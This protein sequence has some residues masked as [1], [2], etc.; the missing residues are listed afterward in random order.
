MTI[1]LHTT[2]MP[3]PPP[4]PASSHEPTPTGGRL[5]AWAEALG[6]AHQLGSALCQT[7]FV[8]ATFRG[9]PEEAAAAILFGDELGL[10]PTQSLQG[11][12]VVSGRVGMYARTMAAIVL[13]AGH[14]V[15]TESKSDAEVVVSGRR[16][17]TQKVITERWTTARA[18]KAGYTSNKKYGSDPQSMLY[19]RALA[20]VCRQIAPDALSGI[21]YTVEELE[22]AEPAPTVT[23]RRADQPAPQPKRT[24]QRKP[25]PVVEDPPLDDEPEP[26]AEA[27][28]VTS[29]QLK[30]VGVLMREQAMTDRA[31][32]LA[33]VSTVI[34][35]DVA[36]RNEL[37][38]DEAH[39]LIEA[40]EAVPLPPEPE[41][42]PE[43]GEV[44]PADLWEGES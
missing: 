40:L 25:P 42:D 3:V 21:A 9:K 28:M 13:A 10:T 38:R 35:R 44:V 36:S 17:G 7:T 39:R 34:G 15:W 4:A 24:V 31:E 2:G 22:L 26:A 20:D 30:K 19:A 32:A 33:Y 29:A 37:T 11:V 16:R 1:A 43:T 23:V 5:V 27:E 41:V 12:F 8:P 18:Q 6:A 14:E